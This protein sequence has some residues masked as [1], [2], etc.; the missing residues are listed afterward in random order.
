[1]PESNNRPRIKFR[2]YILVVAV[3][4]GLIFTSLCMLKAIWGFSWKEVFI[5]F[6]FMTAVV[7]VGTYFVGKV[8]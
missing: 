7:L 6:P 5:E 1:M 3:L 4:A 2:D 8:K